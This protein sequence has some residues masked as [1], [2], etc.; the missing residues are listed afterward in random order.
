MLWCSAEGFD[1]VVSRRPGN[2]LG[3]SDNVYHAMR[4]DRHKESAKGKMWTKDLI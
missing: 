4:F 2:V 1:T 3:V